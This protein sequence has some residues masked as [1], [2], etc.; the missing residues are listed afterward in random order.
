[1]SRRNAR[2]ENRLSKAALT[3]AGSAMRVRTLSLVDDWGTAV[4]AAWL[5]V[6]FLWGQR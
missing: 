4:A 6:E 1:L 5:K 2:A 3:L